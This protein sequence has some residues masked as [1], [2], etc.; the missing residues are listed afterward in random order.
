[1][2]TVVC[3]HIRSNTLISALQVLSTIVHDLGDIPRAKSDK[4]L[5]GI[6]EHR[7]IS[8]VGRNEETQ[9]LLGKVHRQLGNINQAQSILEASVD[10]SEK[11]YGKDHI[12]KLLFT[13]V[14]P[15]VS[16]EEGYI[17]LI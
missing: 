13:K 1:M 7:Q 15:F 11:T 16:Q 5:E 17:A 4:L 10:Q 3:T 14:K 6:E 9:L 2:P 12:R 8:G